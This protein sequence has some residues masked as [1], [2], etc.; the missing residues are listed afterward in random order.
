L[1]EV[2][3]FNPGHTLQCKINKAPDLFALYG[4]A[5]VKVDFFGQETQT[6]IKMYED[7]ART[8]AECK[9]LIDFHGATKPRG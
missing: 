8:T 5:G 3:N 9:I 4:V 7:I 1:R 6:G 2:Y